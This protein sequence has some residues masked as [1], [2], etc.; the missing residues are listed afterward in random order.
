M[1]DEALNRT[2]TAFNGRKFT[3]AAHQAAEGLA[4]ASGSD[5]A[6]WM[7]LN[8]ACEGF[9][10]LSDQK[11]AHAEQKL[12]SAMRTLRNFGFRYGNFEV[13]SALAG[14]RRVIE[15]IRLVRTNK[16]KIFDLSL[17]PRMKMAAKADD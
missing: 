11:Y 16:T 5:E 2:I 13:T 7:G 12:V 14:I 4:G 10:Y 1:N 17:L 15:E 6:F 3:D 8:E 9:M